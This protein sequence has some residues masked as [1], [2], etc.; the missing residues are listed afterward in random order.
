[1]DE[2][3]IVGVVTLIIIACIGIFALQSIADTRACKMEAAAKG[4]NVKEICE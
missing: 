3:F 4:Y 1:M 2:A